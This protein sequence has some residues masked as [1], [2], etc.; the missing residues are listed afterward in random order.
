MP[1]F[2]KTLKKQG[3]TLVEI[4]VTIVLV[5]ILAGLISLVVHSSLD[6]AEASRVIS[7]LR[8]VKSAIHAYAM[9]SGWP[10]PLTL[11]P[12]FPQKIDNYLDRSIFGS[13]GPAQY[14]LVVRNV[15]TPNGRMV[16]GLKPA[17]GTGRFD[18]SVIRKLAQ[19][20][21]TSGLFADNP[22]IEFPGADGENA[23]YVLMYVK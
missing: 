4:L 21:K 11:S 9:D 22:P 1:L 17:S 7:D 3:F 12:D 18:V 20:A 16:I 5:S 2:S 14:D 10:D 8:N 6:G 19:Q 23:D 15:S 13:H